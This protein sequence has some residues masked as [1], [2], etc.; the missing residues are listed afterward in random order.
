M[1]QSGKERGRAG[2]LLYISQ[3]H[4]CFKSSALELRFRAHLN[5]KCNMAIYKK[6]KHVISKG[7]FS[8][9]AMGV[10]ILKKQINSPH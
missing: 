5:M 8:R 6:V 3:L 2:I 10:S 9:N 4:L 7:A 1:G